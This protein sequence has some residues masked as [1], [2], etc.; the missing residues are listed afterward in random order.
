MAEPNRWT[1][2]AG[3]H[4]APANDG[5]RQ[6]F[7]RVG[8]RLGRVT[9]DLDDP[10]RAGRSSRPAVIWW[11]SG[12]T[13]RSQHELRAGISSFRLEYPPASVHAGGRHL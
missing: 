5:K 6:E 8:K 10:Y 9:V 2:C 7:A 13:G 3:V 1:S 12:I 11:P 4:N